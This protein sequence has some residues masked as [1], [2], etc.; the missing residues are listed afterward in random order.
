[1]TFVVKKSTKCDLLKEYYYEKDVI[2]ILGYKLP[3]EEN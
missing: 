2:K 3:E 1:M